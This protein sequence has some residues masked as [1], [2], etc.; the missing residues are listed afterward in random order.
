MA[1]VT[2]ENDDCLARAS[3]RLPDGCARAGEGLPGAEVEQ[4][5]GVLMALTGAS[6][7]AA[8]AELV[9][10]ALRDGRSLT[11]EARTL[12]AGLR[13][14]LAA[15]GAGAEV[16]EAL[17][18]AFGTVPDLLGASAVAPWAAPEAFLEAGGSGAAPEEE[19]G[20]EQAVDGAIVRL[21]DALPGMVVLLTPL[22]GPGGHVTDF[23][24]DAASSG[25]VDIF[26]VSGRDLIGRR[27][28]TA[29]PHLRGTP[30]WEGYLT[31]LATSTVWSGEPFEM[32]DAADGVVRLS[33]FLVRAAP[34]NGRL[35]LS[36]ARLNADARDQRRLDVMQRLGNLGWADWDVAAD[37]ATWSERAYAILER[38]PADGP[39]TLAGLPRLV[40][41]EDSAGLEEDLR[42]LLAEG[43]PVDRT[44]RIDPPSGIRYVRLVAE[45]ERAADGSPIEVRGFLQDVT[46][47]KRAEQ[48]ILAHE[49][50]AHLQLGRL[51]AERALAARLQ[52]ALLPIAQESR[53]LSGLQVDVAYRPAEQGLNVSGD[54]YSA[55]ELPDGSALL[56]VGDV[57]G[58]GLDSVATMAQLRFTAKGMAVTGTPLPDILA[59][60]NTV[61]LHAADGHINTA[62]MIMARYRPDTRRLSW[63]QAGHL[64]PLMI[65]DGLPLILD[66]P[67]GVLLGATPDPVYTE[68]VVTLDPGDELV[69]YTDG[70]IEKPG[71]SL[72][73]GFARLTATAAATPPGVNLLDHLLAR[74]DAPGGRRDDI[75]ALHI[76]AGS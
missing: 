62:T 4:A 15:P 9:R 8:E 36:W 68:A 61:L 17:P 32:E 42:R 24:M 74:L 70:L 59:R 37:T 7:E 2:Q 29:Y 53:T 54:W 14:H 72:D 71:E 3:A 19:P 63:V 22:R 75:C 31:A 47:A 30:L 10:R 11:D 58:H 41:G 35:V 67:A 56:V 33:R 20:A 44:C 21:F 5:K 60:L 28:L 50:N 27:L 65:H 23:R 52:E 13:P 26:G 57:G 43:T 55:V 69:L 66:R 12:L 48:E 6:A 76:L 25:A 18:P 51:R 16:P 1:D 49:R 73:D 45:S 64:P 34:W 40:A 46:A 38:D 39:V